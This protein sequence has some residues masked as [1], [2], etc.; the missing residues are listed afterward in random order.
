LRKVGIIVETVWD[1]RNSNSTY[2]AA[3]PILT[4][5]LSGPYDDGTKEGI[6][7]ALTVK[8]ARGISADVLFDEY[9]SRKDESTYKWSLAN[10]LSLVADKSLEAKLIEIVFDP[11]HACGRASLMEALAKIRS[12]RA[13]EAFQKLVRDPDPDIV[14]KAKKL[15][16][17]RSWL[18]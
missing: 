7:R 11:E 10:A 14:V 8:E 9:V 1:F 2:P 13:K 6:A 16:K 17:R 5:H 4:N 3:I 12:P 18:Q 15:M